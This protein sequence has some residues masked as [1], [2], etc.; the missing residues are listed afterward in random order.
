MKKMKIINEMLDKASDLA[1]ELIKDEARKILKADDSLDEFVMGMGSCFFT[2]KDGGKYDI[3]SYTDEQ[4]DQMDED[5]HDWYGAKNGILHDRF[6]PEFMEM[7]DDLN[8][9]F[10]VCGY[11]VRFKANSKE[12]YTWGD[13]GK[14]PVEYEDNNG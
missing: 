4:Y 9:K 5:G 2:Y 7:V 11:P 10:N 14:N 6:Q 12:V 13:T 8:D 1:I 3:F